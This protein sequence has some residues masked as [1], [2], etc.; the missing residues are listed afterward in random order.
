[1]GGGSGLDVI[2]RNI[3]RILSSYKGLDEWQPWYDIGED[4]AIVI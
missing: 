4:D 2:D 1:M 3:L